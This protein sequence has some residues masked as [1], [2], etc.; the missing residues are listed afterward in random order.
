M[1]D[2][3]PPGV[4]SS[5][6][7]SSTQHQQKNA[8]RRHN[9][10][11]KL[12]NSAATASPSGTNHNPFNTSFTFDDDVD[13][14]DV[15]STGL[16]ARTVSSLSTTNSST[17]AG[18]SSSFSR[19]KNNRPRDTY[20]MSNNSSTTSQQP[21]G[22]MG[23]GL[24]LGGGS[25]A[26]SSSPY[27]ATTTDPNVLHGASTPTNG[28]LSML[29]Y[30]DDSHTQSQMSRLM[31]TTP[32]DDYRSPGGGGPL[33][34]ANDDDSPDD[35]V[36]R[37][38]P[39]YMRFSAGLLTLS[40]VL[41]SA[42]QNLASPHLSDIA[43]D[44]FR[45]TC[46]AEFPDDTKQQD[47]CV[48][49]RKLQQLGGEAQF[50]FFILGGL[51]TLLIGP[52]AD[53]YPRVRLLVLVIWVGSL[54]CLLTIFIPNGLFGFYCFMTQR[55]LT[56]ISVGGS[57]PIIYSV[58]ADIF[59]P[60]W[61]AFIGTLVASGTAAGIGIG[62][63]LSGI[64]GT[65]TG[66]RFVFFL[67]ALPSLVISVFAV[68]SVIEPKRERPRLS[69]SASKQRSRSSEIV[70]DDM[71]AG[72]G[73][74]NRQHSAGTSNGAHQYPNSGSNTDIENAFPGEMDNL[75]HSPIMSGRHQHNHTAGTTSPSNAAAGLNHAIVPPS[76]PSSQ[77]RQA[78]K[79]KEEWKKL[80][81]HKR[82][83]R[84]VTNNPTTSLC[85]LQSIPGCVPWATVQVYVLDYMHHDLNY[86][87][88]SATYVIG[89]F[90]VSGM[91]L[92]IL[93][94]W[95]ANYFSKFNPRN[96]ALLSSVPAVIVWFCLRGILFLVSLTDRKQN[97]ETSSNNAAYTT[98][99]L[100]IYVLA[101]FAGFGAITG[102]TVKGL[103]L[104]CN[105]SQIRGTVCGLV[106]LTDD[107]GKG[108]APIIVAHYMQVLGKDVAIGRALDCFLLCAFV[109]FLTYFTIRDDFIHFDSSSAAGGSKSLDPGGFENRT[110]LADVVSPAGGVN[111][112]HDYSSS[113]A[114]AG[115]TSTSA[116]KNII[117]QQQH[118]T[119]TSSSKINHTYGSPIRD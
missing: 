37:R 91:V 43:D 5:T 15:I 74:S 25:S 68:L 71:G 36:Y 52:M 2:F 89:I 18:A 80:E 115:S 95:L 67:I 30:S 85:L 53:V 4:S 77:Q 34:L 51:A 57:Y 78:N 112:D 81:L 69:R 3:S 96:L 103:L 35:S 92:V 110:S 82:L 107:L 7:T 21:H 104:N 97:G 75:D 13:D 106:T 39:K 40:V 56:G 8:A 58:L 17:G 12:R 118:Y 66:W 113:Y 100:L 50:G 90:M 114:T 84:G 49:H 33:Q 16:L 93:S 61:K 27:I 94:S 38:N 46:Q 48:D 65:Q 1:D 87:L 54:P 105:G 109:N 73:T 6:S 41:L 24:N 32:V 59:P 19:F 31:Q 55:I 86:P 99:Q 116:G 28:M 20:S 70:G 62:T 60:S 76:T 72:G 9:S 98:T 79:L 42:D 117:T 47:S 119:T 22:G 83:Y 108:F 102:P 10:K 64:I 101:I 88:K 14:F 44:F 111:M 63:F 45:E 29:Q 23:M 11:S 26:S